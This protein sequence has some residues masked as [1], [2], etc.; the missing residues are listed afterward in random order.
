MT[1][2]LVVYGRNDSYGYNM[3]K[4]VAISLN[5]IAEVLTGSD[6]EII[7]V[8][9]NTSNNLPTFIE[10]IADTLTDKAKSLVRVLRVR[11]E[12]HEK[13]K[14]LTHAQ[15]NEAL[16]RNIGVRRSNP[17]NKWIISTNTDVVFSVLEQ[18]KSLSQLIA[19]TEDGFYEVARFDVPEPM[20]ESLDRKNP[21]QIINIFRKW[22]QQFH[23]NE[24]V[25]GNDTIIYDAPGDF[26]LM[27]RDD[28]FAING[29]DE[30]MILGWHVDSNLCKRMKLLRGEVR[31]LQSKVYSYHC[32]HTR[33]AGWQHTTTRKTENC[34]LKYFEDV[35]SPYLPNQKESWGLSGHEIEELRIGTDTTSKFVEN[36]SAVINEPL[37][38]EYGESFFNAAGYNDVFYS[39]NHVAPYFF[40]QISLLPP[41]SKIT[42]FGYNKMMVDRLRKFIAVLDKN[43]ELNCYQSFPQDIQNHDVL[44]QKFDFSDLDLSLIN[45]SKLA[46]K[47]DLLVF[48]FG[49][50]NSMR[51]DFNSD[52]E[53]I[54]N[55]LWRQNLVAKIISHKITLKEIKVIALGVHNTQY[56]KTIKKFFQPIQNPYN[57]R[58][59]VGHKVSVIESIRQR[60]YYNYLVGNISSMMAKKGDFYCIVIL[61]F[62]SWLLTVNGILTCKAKLLGLVYKDFRDNK[63]LK[64]HDRLPR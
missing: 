15:V 55:L 45:D 43:I 35:T 47:S 33:M 10:A 41:N 8:D 48:D 18:G 60:F 7:F 40:E 32:N 26:Q 53:L 64:A 5:C 46:T 17:K 42:Y 38:K 62:Y 61:P 57:G 9:Y 23:L 29:F 20:W 14:L 63:K 50:D 34:L 24:V 22:G 56:Y 3:H 13:F 39:T 44:K 37:Q 31:S 12:I 36:L 19:E 58:V 21:Q 25:Y 51:Q 11:P 27:L 49:F 2:S 59:M 1:V 30:D 54:L 6:D 28:I 16:A 52:H 4:R